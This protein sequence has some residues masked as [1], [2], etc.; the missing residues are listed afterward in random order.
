MRGGCRSSAGGARNA[1]S[2]QFGAEIADGVTEFLEDFV[3]RQDEAVLVVYL[4]GG[5]VGDVPA[6]GGEVLAG[7]T[8]LTVPDEFG[9]VDIQS[10]L[11][12]GFAHRPSP[13]VGEHPHIGD[14]LR[15]QPAARGAERCDVVQEPVLG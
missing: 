2:S 6:G 3:V 1:S 5:V 4:F 8:A 13:L 14:V 10:V 7:R 12:P 9:D 11:S 15:G